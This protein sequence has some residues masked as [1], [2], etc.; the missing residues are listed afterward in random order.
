MAIVTIKSPPDGTDVTAN[1]VSRFL[2]VIP[3]G[4][5]VKE[6]LIG[7]AKFYTRQREL[8]LYRQAQ[9][10][11]ASGNVQQRSQDLSADPDIGGGE[12]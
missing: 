1:M 2:A 8:I 7:L 12:F 11:L 9:S 5:T 4:M 3:P 6:A 10:A